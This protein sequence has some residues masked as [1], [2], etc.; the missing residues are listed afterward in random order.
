MKKLMMAV[1][2]VCAAAGVQAASIEWNSNLM[3]LTDADG[4]VLNTAAALDNVVLVTL[5]ST[6]DWDNATVIAKAATETEGK[7]TMKIGTQATTAAKAGRVSGK[8]KFAYDGEATAGNLINNGDYLAL[9][10]Q[11]ENGNLSQ[12]KYTTGTDKGDAVVATLK[13]EGL[14]DNSTALSSGMSIA[15]TGNFTA[16]VPEPTSAMLLLLGMAG[17]ALRRRRA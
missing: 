8:V 11:D 4:V 6:I 15:M 5:G 12:L 13:V 17:L 16:A 10:V 2:V 3:Q 9:M 1:A 7:T 14:V